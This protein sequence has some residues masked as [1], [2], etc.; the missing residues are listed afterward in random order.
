MRRPEVHLS[1][2]HRNRA[3]SIPICSI[4]MGG[5]GGGGKTGMAEN[6]GKKKEK[7]PTPPL[8]APRRT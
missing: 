7:N 5:G 4:A 8:G 2:V 1:S 3:T 6:P